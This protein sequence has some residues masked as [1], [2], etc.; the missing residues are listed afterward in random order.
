MPG[1]GAVLL[2]GNGKS[3]CAGMDLNEVLS[4]GGG[5]INDVHERI[6]TAGIRMTKPLI[7]RGARSGAGGRHGPGSQLPHRRGGRMR[8]RSG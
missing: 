5:D 3:F 6:F 7:A 2:C 1:V 4:P 8:P